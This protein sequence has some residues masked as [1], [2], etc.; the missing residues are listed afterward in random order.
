MDLKTQMAVGERFGRLHV[1]PVYGDREPVA[2]LQIHT[3]EHS[4]YAPG[5]HWHTDVSSDGRPPAL[6]ILRIEITPPVGGDTVFASTTAALDAMSVP[7]R[8]FLETLSAVHVYRNVVTANRRRRH[9]RSCVH[10]R[11]RTIKPLC[12]RRVH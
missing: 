5:D 3:D 6:S 4:V 10:I 9:T 11:D 2:A 8:S 1:H 7:M 12:E